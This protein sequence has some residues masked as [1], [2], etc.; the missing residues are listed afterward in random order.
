MAK[1]PNY[2]CGG[3]LHIPIFWW[4]R[5]QQGQLPN[6]YSFGATCLCLCLTL[7]FR[8]QCGPLQ[9]QPHESPSFF[10]E[11]GALPLGSRPD[12]AADSYLSCPGSPFS[13]RHSAGPIV[14]KLRVQQSQKLCCCPTVPQPRR[15]KGLNSP[16]SLTW[17]GK[18]CLGRVGGARR[19]QEKGLGG[20]ERKR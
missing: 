12:I 2:F 9:M 13:R 10:S 7:T 3:N 14:Y 20:W 19:R 1:N 11:G 5:Y 17:V 8:D 15:V 18:R 6:L 4:K 16:Y